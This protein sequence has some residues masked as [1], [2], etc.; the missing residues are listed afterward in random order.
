MDMSKIQRALGFIEGICTGL[1]EKE[2]ELIEGAIVEID[3]ELEG[4]EVL[5]PAGQEHTT[6]AENQELVE[7]LYG[8]LR[9]M[10]PGKSVEMYQMAEDCARAASLIE[11]LMDQLEG[12]D[13]GTYAERP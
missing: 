1:K 9:K 10:S 7:R 5:R 11:Q 12:R 13:Y 8:Y 2:A 6:T 3:C 4:S